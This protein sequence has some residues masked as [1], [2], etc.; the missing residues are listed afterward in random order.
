MKRF[1]ISLISVITVVSA[2]ACFGPPPTDNYYMFS[3]IDRKYFDESQQSSGTDFW[4]KYIGDESGAYESTSLANVDLKEF[5]KSKNKIIRTAIKRKDKETINYLKLIIEYSQNNGS[6]DRWEYPT[7]QQLAQRKVTLNRIKKAA[8]AYKG[9][10][11]K[12]RYAY[13][14]MRCNMTQKTHKDNVYYWEKVASK[15]KDNL[16]KVEMKNMYAGAL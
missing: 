2:W 13:L 1:Y 12:N 6:N 14:V 16:F 4:N 11:Y 9:T 7:K 15:L 10:R 5:N 8:M 3:V